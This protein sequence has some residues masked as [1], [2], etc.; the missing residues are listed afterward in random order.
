MKLIFAFLLLNFSL[1]AQETL[2]E[3]YKLSDDFFFKYVTDG[4]VN[5]SEIKRNSTELQQLTKSISEI[6]FDDLDDANKKA[7]LINVY[8]LSVIQQV[9]SKYPLKSPMDVSGFFDKTK[10]NLGGKYY[11]LN[12]IENDLLRKKFKE[13]RF[14]FVLVCGA[15]GCPVITNFA[16]NPIDLEQ[17]L[18]QQTKAALNNSSFVYTKNGVVYLSEIFKW[19]ISDFGGGNYSTVKYINGFR[20]SAFNLG[21]KVIHYPYDWKLNEFKGAINQKEIQQPPVI[22]IMEVEKN[23]VESTQQE[24]QKEI[25]PTDEEV[26]T[27]SVDA[28]EIVTE[29]AIDTFEATDEGMNDEV[30][31]DFEPQQVNLQTYTA[32]TLLRKGQFDFTTFNTIYTQT[33]SNWLGTNFNNQRETFFTSS[34]QVLYGITKN[35]RVNVGFELN[36]KSSA[37]SNDTR[38]GTT[39]NAFD[40][41]N[42]DSTRVGLANAGLKIKVSP[43]KGVNDFTIQSTF[44]V[45]TITNPEGYTN[46]DGSGNGNLYWSDWN[47]YTSWTQFFYVKSFNKFQVFTEVDLLYRIRTNRQQITH[48]DL[49]STLIFSYFPTSI[50]TIYAIG[51]HTTRYTQNIHPN[52]ATDWVI[53]MNFTTAGLGLKVQPKSN[54]TI[55]FLYTKFVR[56]INTGLGSTFNIGVKFLTK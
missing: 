34:L 19:Y 38:V 45:P 39:F 26:E 41:K 30:E 8:N 24:Q 28:T 37:R 56:G 36:F 46:P 55:E 9:A 15:L 53:P 3:F 42:N 5:Y 10:F 50:L 7:Y 52:E 21:A 22:T 12:A 32:G 23:E 13:P 16:Y 4:K 29:T 35:K 14:H 43:F 25:T 40:F 51:Q 1:G 17:Q 6:G 54:I 18:E 44:Y 47:R 2:T 27:E 31:I 33:K 49:P 11:T 20:S 48:L